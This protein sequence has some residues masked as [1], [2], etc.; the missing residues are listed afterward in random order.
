VSKSVQE[1][2]APILSKYGA[3]G[4]C[5]GY[6]YKQSSLTWREKIW[7]GVLFKQVN[8]SARGCWWRG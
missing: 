7:L 1:R 6:K 4:A 5:W 3:D 8:V 2:D